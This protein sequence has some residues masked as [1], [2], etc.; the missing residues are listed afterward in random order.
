MK[1]RTLLL[2][3]GLSF[4]L[5]ACGR[6][7][8]VKEQASSK[9]VEEVTKQEDEETLAEDT[10]KEVLEEA[11]PEEE[12]AAEVLEEAEPEEEQVA[13]VPVEE[14]DP[15]EAEER[16]TK[17]EI[18]D[19]LYE[20][21]KECSLLYVQPNEEI[22]DVLFWAVCNHITEGSDFTVIAPPEV[23]MG[24]PYY[25]RTIAVQSGD[26]KYWLPNRNVDIWAPKMSQEEYQTAFDN[27]NADDIISSELYYDSYVLDFYSGDYT[28]SRDVEYIAGIRDIKIIE[29]SD[30]GI[31]YVAEGT[32]TF[33]AND[34]IFWQLGEKINVIPLPEYTIVSEVV[35][36]RT[37]FVQI[38]FL[39]KGDQLI[40]TV[41]IAGNG[42]YMFLD[43]YTCISLRK[44]PENLDNNLLNMD[45]WGFFV[46]E[47]YGN[48]F[49]INYIDMKTNT[50]TEIISR[51]NVSKVSAKRSE[52]VL[53]N[54]KVTYSDK[55]EEYVFFENA[56]YG[57]SEY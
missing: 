56:I 52:S 12:Q 20:L 10:A 38:V 49:H 42:N 40:S 4:M 15:A 17:E 5:V 54:I 28:L 47:K 21:N 27:L 32:W 18:M 41:I 6:S 39:K 43:N 16:R 55:T 7:A 8:E 33:D 22:M 1:K 9:E 25:K 24:S 44:S 37:D 35:A 19:I 30:K 53:Q 23:F 26:V 31:Y 48:V 50:T 45:G 13:E 29:P 11:E 14:T 46:G 34:M 51:D 2:V 3:L 36:D 57:D